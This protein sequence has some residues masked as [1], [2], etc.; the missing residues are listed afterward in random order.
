MADLTAHTREH[1]DLAGLY[2]L[3]ALEPE[4]T[5]VF[6]RHLA[7][8]SRCQDVVEADRHTV[9]L[10]SAA[11]PEMEAS[12]GFKDRLM[13]R[14]ARDIA[15]APTAPQPLPRRVAEVQPTRAQ[16]PARPFIW[17]P[18]GWMLAPLAAA[19]AVALGLGTLVGQQVY[20]SQ[21][22]ASAVFPAQGGGQATVLVRRSG[23]AEIALQGLPEP[24]AGR[25]Y[26]AWAIPDGGTPLPD[27]TTASG[28]GTIALQQPV[29]GRTVA[30]TLEPAPGV[31]APTTQPIL[32]GKVG[33]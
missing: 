3:S 28:Q 33:A 16:E 2:A 26:Q 1:E 6:E 11:A 20:G 12:P 24:P 17:L 27:G 19:F 7:T 21:V 25:V 31:S 15:A 29:L 4:E 10:L 18:R 22:L 23:A 9:R 8:C 13:A 14:A 5:V 30:I 32:A